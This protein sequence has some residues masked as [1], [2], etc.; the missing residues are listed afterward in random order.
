M[1]ILIEAYACRPGRGSEDGNGWFLPLELA[2]LGHEVTVVTRTDYADEVQAA[3]AQLIA[4]EPEL[5]A[6]WQF[7]FVE[8]PRWTNL[9]PKALR[10]RARHWLWLEQVPQH[11]AGLGRFDLAWHITWGSL[12]GGTRLHRLRLPVVHGPCGGGHCTDP[13]V[14]NLFGPQ[15]VWESL[16]RGT[17]RLVRH[18]RPVWIRRTSLVLCSNRETQL[19]ARDLGA[20]R[21]GLCSDAGLPATFRPHSLPK[22]EI[23]ST[24]RLLWIGRLL[25]L[26]AVRLAIRVMENLPA[27]LPVHL[28]IIG[29]GEEGPWLAQALASSPARGR[30]TWRGRIPWQEVP[31]ALSQADAMLFTSVRDSCA[32]QVFEAMCHGLPV[33]AIRQFGIRDH[34]G[35]GITW[36]RPGAPEELVRDFVNAIMRLQA[37]PSL[38]RHLGRIN[39]ANAAN[40]LWPNR[41]RHLLRM[42]DAALNGRTRS[43]HTE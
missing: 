39:H 38:R 5:A 27:D 26:K 32:A 33:I 6:R 31:A 9:L 25:P 15:A 37:S 36:V 42:I 41:A 29:D 12:L 20:V 14:L 4:V 28:D 22:R 3:R 18:W 8:P 34:A 16:R 23:G 17:L 1:R 43:S 2:R 7:A 40:C 24:F 30:I 35:R 11:A 13:R 19:L 21:A 10:H